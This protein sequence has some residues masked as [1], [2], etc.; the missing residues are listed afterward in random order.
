MPVEPPTFTDLVQ[1]PR[2]I[3]EL[4]NRELLEMGRQDPRQL[5]VRSLRRAYREVRREYAASLRAAQAH[6]D[7]DGRTPSPQAPER[8]HIES[9]LA[10]GKRLETAL[11]L[12]HQEQPRNAATP[13]R[14]APVLVREL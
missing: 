4:S 14:I 10:E 3:V 9:L 7:T 13:G 12:L 5:F 2:R 11:A 6:H 1:N 8:R